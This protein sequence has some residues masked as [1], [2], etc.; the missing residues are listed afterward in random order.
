M[1]RSDCI[2]FLEGRAPIGCN[3]THWHSPTPYTLYPIC[4]LSLGTD[5]L[6]LVCVV[7]VVCASRVNTYNIVGINIS[8]VEHADRDGT[9][10][11][12]PVVTDVVKDA[13]QRN[14]KSNFGF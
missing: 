4:L 6:S 10:G 9:T 1:N 3:E 13:A 11:H 12:S 7:C 8:P 14:S 5:R 2:I